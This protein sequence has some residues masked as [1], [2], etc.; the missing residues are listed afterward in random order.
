MRPAMRG[1]RGRSISIF[2]I[3]A[4]FVLMGGMFLLYLTVATSLGAFDAGFATWMKLGG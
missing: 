1:A 2:Y 3:S 4:P